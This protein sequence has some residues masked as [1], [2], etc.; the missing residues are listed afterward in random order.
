MN[1][2]LPEAPAMSAATESIIRETL[3]ASNAGRIH[4]GQVVG[5]L[6]AAGVESYAVD[7]RAGRAVYYL[8]DGASLSLALE[9]PMAP[10]AGEFS[11]AGIRAAIAGAQR[12][13][14]MYPE[15]K[16]LS[17]AA[18]CV[19]YTVWLAGRHVAYYGRKG[20]THCEYFPD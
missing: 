20:E 17:Q 16:R 4:F 7:Y 2:A 9:M 19:G 10:I 15:F 14:V 8:P 18:G 11:A 1:P 13:E 12:G 5:Q 6:L 3:A